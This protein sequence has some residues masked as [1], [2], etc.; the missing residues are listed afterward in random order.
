MGAMSRAV[1][2]MTGKLLTIYAF[3]LFTTGLR[4]QPMHYLAY[5]QGST[6]NNPLDS[7]AFPKLPRWFSGDQTALSRVVGNP[8]RDTTGML[9]ALLAVGASYDETESLLHQLNTGQELFKFH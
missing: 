1:V 8:M 6:K 4:P 5:L 3:T 7:Y 9:V 2:S